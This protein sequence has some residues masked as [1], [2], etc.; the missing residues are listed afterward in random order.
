MTWCISSTCRQS[1]AERLPECCCCSQSH[2]PPC[3]CSANAAL[4]VLV[5]TY[6]EYLTQP[7]CSALGPWHTVIHTLAQAILRPEHSVDNEALISMLLTDK[8][9][10]KVT[11]SNS[12]QQADAG[13]IRDHIISKLAE[14]VSLSGF[15]DCARQQLWT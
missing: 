11:G 6:A 12:L 8:R 5:H 7:G 14:E 1:A 2:S 10:H 4:Q 3:R 15:A 13:E 9:L